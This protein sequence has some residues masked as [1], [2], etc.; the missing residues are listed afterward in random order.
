MLPAGY[1]LRPLRPADYDAVRKLWEQTEGVGLNE[2][3]SREAITVFLA[4]NPELSLV[5]LD[6]AGTISGA[7]LCGHDGRRGYLHHLAVTPLQRGRGLGRALVDEA[8]DRL[9]ASGIPKC[10]IYLFATNH[11]GRTFWM[12]EGWSVRDDLLVLQ[13]GLSGC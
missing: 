7:V 3:D 13:R 2:S 9:R 10:N 12:H 1:A 6:P 8:L 5:A 11:S 4:R